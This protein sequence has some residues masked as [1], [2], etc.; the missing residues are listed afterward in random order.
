MKF[1]AK[2][3][4]LAIGLAATSSLWAASYTYEAIT[5]F[6][7]TNAGEVP[8]YRHNS[9]N[10]LAINAAIEANRN[11]LARATLVFEEATGTY[12]VTITSL[13]E[14]DGDGTFQ[15]LV[16]GVVVGSAVNFPTT[17]DYSEQQHTFENINIPQGAL[18]GVESTAVSNDTVPEGDGFAY[19]R[20]RWTKLTIVDVED[21]TTTPN[22]PV[23]DL[24]LNLSANSNSVT[25]ATELTYS[26]VVENSSNDIATNPS[27]VVSLPAGLANIA[28]DSCTETTTGTLLCDLAELNNNETSEFTITATTTTAG[29]ISVMAEVNA[30]Q[31]DPDA[32]NNSDSVEVVVTDAPTPPDNTVNLDLSLSADKQRVEVGESV[33]YSLTVTNVHQSNT[34]TAPTLGVTLPDSLTFESSDI[35]TADESAVICLTEE[36]P[37]NASIETQFRVTTVTVD[38][39]AQLLATASSDQPERITENNEAQLVTDITAVS[40]QTP[41]ETT[42]ASANKVSGGGVI[43]TPSLLLL[44]LAGAFSARRHYS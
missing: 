3:L 35:C 44:L 36:L 18:I 4:A 2:T 12:D 19:A 16:D 1:A 21:T 15:F 34:A 22:I 8:Y 13:G 39:Y 9:V 24:S 23:V 6:T 40:Y 5:D 28:S 11:K 38:S 10:A 14:I 25:T 41:A 20:G 27:V 33:T 7:D 30:D 43:A 42:T 29:A 17:E 37:P 32:T 31:S 26:V